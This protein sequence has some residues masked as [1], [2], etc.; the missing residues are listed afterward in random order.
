MKQ[1]DAWLAYSPG[2]MVVLLI[3]GVL[4]MDACTIEE[5]APKQQDVV[6]PTDVTGDNTPSSDVVEVPLPECGDGTCDWAEACLTCPEDC[7]CAQL[8]ATPPMGW[9]SWNLFA[10]DID[11]VLVREMADAMVETGM[12]EVGYEYVNLDDC[13]QV[14]RDEDGGIVA[15]PERFPSG[16][17]ALADYVHDRGLKLGIYTCAGTLTCEGRPGS[18]GY[19]AQDMQTYADWGVD[20]VKVDWCY[21]DGLDSAERYELFREGIDASGREILLSICNWGYQDPWVWG[22]D[23]GE[24]WRTSLD[25]KDWFESLMFNVMAVEPLAAFAGPGRWNDPDMLEV[26]NGGMTDDLY[27]AHFGLW[28]MFAAPL[29][30]GNDLRDMT[31]ATLEILTNPEV[32]A[33]DQDPAGLQAVLVRVSDDVRVY[34]RALTQDGLRAVLFFNTSK[35]SVGAASITWK[36][37]GL[38]QGTA[39]VR[40]LFAMED[41]GAFEGAFEAEI[42]PTS[43]VMVTI[44]GTEPLPGPG[45]NY[46]SDMNLKYAASYGGPVALDHAFTPESEDPGPIIDLGEQTHEKGLGVPGGSVVVVHLGGRCDVFEATLGLTTNAGPGGSVVFE[47]WAD[48]VKIW[49]SD[50]VTADT[51]PIPLQASMTGR[52]NLKLVTTPAGDS[53][54]GDR[55]AWGHAHLTCE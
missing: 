6:D 14:E 49:G 36:E 34:S 40:D 55:A 48:G 46:L 52:Q 15:D 42:P 50:V 17:A 31:P 27:R 32:I 43:A 44:H 12:Q 26:G 38:L 45:I 23:M 3:V 54:A 41:L 13:W 29:I 37:L 24:M 53:T 7:S 5:E 22:P 28:A 10:C 51:D 1:A 35:D 21:T 4:W 11:E 25:I 2:G 20:L 8:A 18:F 30:A 16:I 39:S 19:E 33:I 9:N 47:V